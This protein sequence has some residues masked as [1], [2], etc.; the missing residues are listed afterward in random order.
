MWSGIE[1]SLDVVASNLP[2]IAPG[3]LK[4]ARSTTAKWSN[5]RTGLFRSSRGKTTAQNTAI[6]VNKFEQDDTSMETMVD[7]RPDNG[8]NASGHLDGR[9]QKSVEETRYDVEQGV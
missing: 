8:P 2:V 6:D 5:I 3:L 9:S 1:V 7:K 4:V